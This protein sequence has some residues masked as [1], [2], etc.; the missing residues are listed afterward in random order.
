MDREF[1]F[2]LMTEA[3]DKGMNLDFAAMCA[4][5]VVRRIES[6]RSH[7]CDEWQTLVHAN[8]GSGPLF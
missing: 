8:D 5:E 7:D 3:V 1:V 2:K 4:G 6:G